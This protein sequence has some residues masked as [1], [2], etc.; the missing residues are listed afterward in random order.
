MNPRRVHH[1]IRDGFPELNAISREWILV[2]DQSGLRR[3]RL[4]ELLKTFISADEVLVEVN[5]KLGDYLPIEEA[6]DFVA[7][8]IGQGNIRLADRLF[9]GFVYVASNGVATGWSVTNSE[10]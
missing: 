9:K 1:L 6:V 10:H 8:H 7:E 5:R 3:Q 4:V 2:A